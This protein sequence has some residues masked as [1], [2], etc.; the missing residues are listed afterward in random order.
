M[1]DALPWLPLHFPD[2]NWNWLSAE[3][4]SRD[5]QNRLAYVT[6]LASDVAQSRGEAD[7]AK[8]LRFRVASLERSRMAKKT[9]WRRAQ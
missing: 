7:L 4:K 8:S 5:R 9:L 6:L 3:V 1:I 2:M